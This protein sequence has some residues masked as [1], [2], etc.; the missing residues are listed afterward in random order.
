MTATFLQSIRNSTDQLVRLCLLLGFNAD[1]GRTNFEKDV[2]SLLFG[3]TRPPPRK[4]REEN[5][6]PDVEQK[7]PVVEPKKPEPAPVVTMP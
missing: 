3:D 7:K 1:R 6:A 2:D 4:R 5:K